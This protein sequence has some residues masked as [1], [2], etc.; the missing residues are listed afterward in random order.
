[1]RRIAWGLLVL[2]GCA[3]GGPPS[4][5]AEL[6]SVAAPLLT[7]VGWIGTP[8]QF[9]DDFGGELATGDF[10][11]DGFDDLVVADPEVLDFGL[12]EGAVHIFPGSANGLAAA[13]TLSLTGGDGYFGTGVSAG[14]L[15]GDGYDDLCVGEPYWDEPSLTDAGRAYVFFGSP[16]GL[17]PAVGWTVEGTQ[18]DGRLGTA[19]AC[20]GDANNDGFDEIAIGASM[21]DAPDS[22]AGRVHV[23]WAAPAVRGSSRS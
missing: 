13:A 14:D 4:G 7:P 17:D 18:A 6:P 20:D 1:M 23:T 22:N 9:S 19:V 15:N 3:G 16:T 12:T 8:P 21:E 10:D 2:L 5:S 11:G